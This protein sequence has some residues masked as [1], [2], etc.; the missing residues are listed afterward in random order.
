MRIEDRSGEALEETTLVVDDE[1]LIDLLQG[2]ADLVEGKRA[3]LHFSQ[4]G[5]PQ[6]VVRHGDAA[7]PI[8]RAADWWVGPLVLF[9][10]LF[11]IIGAITV[12]RWAV[13]LIA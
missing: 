7:D 11:I 2:L 9:G 6:L 8:E 10:A 1:E 4:P 5:G 3:H 13:G 12:F